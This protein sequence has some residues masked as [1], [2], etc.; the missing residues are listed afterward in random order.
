V[1]IG[2]LPELEVDTDIR[3]EAPVDDGKLKVVD[4][5]CLEDD[6]NVVDVVVVEG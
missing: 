4:E 3:A 5:F 2:S 1:S 6:P